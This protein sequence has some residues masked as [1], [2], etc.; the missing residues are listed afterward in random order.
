MPTVWDV[1]RTRVLN[2]P[3]LLSHAGGRS[4]VFVLDPGAGLG[5]SCLSK[6]FHSWTRW[7]RKINMDAAFFAMECFLGLIDNCK[8]F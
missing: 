4:H 8:N 5:L 6:L 3:I 2:F 7:G 1:L